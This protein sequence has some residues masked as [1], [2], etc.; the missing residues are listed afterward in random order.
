[1]RRLLNLNEVSTKF[2]AAIGLL[3]GGIPV[4]LWLVSLL[5]RAAHVSSGIIL[6]L[7]KVSLILGGL[8]LALFLILI[9]LEQVQD[10]YL[11]R[12]YLKGRGQRIRSAN[13]EAECPFCGNRQVQDF[14]K[15]CSVCGKELKG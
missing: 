15:R 14:E 13:G 1:M 11:H 9:V 10:H 2:L 8:L 7:I 5:L 3:V 6:D 4:L 12:V